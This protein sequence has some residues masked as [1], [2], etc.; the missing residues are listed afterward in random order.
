M[1]N[2]RLSESPQSSELNT[3]VCT[4]C[5]KELPISKFSA[6]KVSKDGYTNECRDCLTNYCKEYQMKSRL[7]RRLEIMMSRSYIW[8]ESL[9]D[10]RK[11]V[12]A[13]FSVS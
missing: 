13:K 7:D 8:G 6:R 10:C 12:I 11:R 9:E 4:H 2:R 1:N 5:K 3:K